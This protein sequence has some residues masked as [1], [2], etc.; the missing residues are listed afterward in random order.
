MANRKYL[1]RV[2]KEYIEERRIGV[3]HEVFTI[4]FILFF[5]AVT[6]SVFFSNWSTQIRI[7]NWG[8]ATVS[9]LTSYIFIYLNRRLIKKMSIQLSVY[10]MIIVS[11]TIVSYFVNSDKLILS[12]I[13]LAFCGIMICFLSYNRLIIAIYSIVVIAMMT[14]LMVNNPIMVIELGRGFI[15][16]TIFG[17][18]IIIYGYLRTIQLVQWF[19]DK[20]NNELK[21]SNEKNTELQALNEEYIAT[22]EALFAQYDEVKALNHTTQLSAERLS[23]IINT[24]DNGII[25]YKI[26]ENVFSL[27]DRAVELLHN[28]STERYTGIAVLTERLGLKSK[29]LLLEA[30]ESVLKGEAENQEIDLTYIFDGE[31]VH[32]RMMLLNYTSKVEYD[33]HV[34]IVLKDITKETKQAKH[35][36]NMAY[37]DDLTGLYSRSGF[38]E[39]LNEE[40]RNGLSEFSIIMLD[41][42][43]F[44]YI[45]D[46]FGYDVG[47]GLIQ[48]V[49]VSLLPFGMK[50]MP[51]G[52]V[53]SDDF[54]LI[55]GYTKD[56]EIVVA[57]INSTKETFT[58]EGTEFSVNYS[59]GIAKYQNNI[60]ATDLLK[61]AELAMYKVKEKGKNGFAYFSEDDS[62]AV[63]QKLMLIN[64]LEKAIAKGEIYMNY[65]PV[66][67][68]TTQDTVGYE[69]LVRWKASEFGQV[70]PEVFVELAEQTGYIYELGNYIIEQVCHFV[71]RMNRSGCGKRMSINIS[72][73][74]LMYDHFIEDFKRILDKTNTNAHCLAIEITES[75]LIDHMEVAID[76]INQIRAL[77][78]LVYLDDFGKGYSSL[79][80][81]NQLPIDVIKIDKS[82]IDFVHKNKKDETMVRTIIGMAK[83]FELTVVAEGVEIE[84]QYETLKA[85]GCDLIQGYYFSKPLSTKAIIQ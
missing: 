8:L 23:A 82:F 84:E 29:E 5:V 56:P 74:Q 14:V 16:A 44:K 61:H 30:W 66:V 64:S 6:A 60:E 40:I 38:V 58:I 79:T 76:S 24:T 9:L 27:S 51:I 31:D 78:I 47:D 62:K 70:S 81:L 53:G 68:A 11:F 57:E 33:Q 21:N 2:S 36:Y 41:I 37:Y 80:Y 35:I 71:N 55:L 15:I 50:G 59:I 10:T 49:A 45:N 4:T 32:Y 22:E 67:D 85:M 43:N 73:R 13:P 34:L 69:A 3:I 48:M 1:P 77:G 54:A 52:R 25:E 39:K 83:N 46:T 42:D 20:L 12:I 26:S 75:A 7:R 18:L 63:H 17:F 65:Q 28:P 72:G 19:G